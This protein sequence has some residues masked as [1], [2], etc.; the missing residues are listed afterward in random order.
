MAH[1]HRSTASLRIIGEALKPEDISE[2][3][4]CAPTY[5]HIKG[6]EWQGKK[7]GKAYI[8]DFGLWALNAND[9][10]PENLDQQVDWL[11]S[12]LT[13]D[14]NIW[15]SIRERYRIDLYCGFFMGES[16]EGMSVSPKTLLA[17]GA[18]GIELGLDIYAPTLEE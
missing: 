1:M 18:R 15:L 7:A 3:L 14:L 9:C 8:K 11:L 13:P 16:N 2:L 4:G 12:K 6:H 5:A 10:E 17:L